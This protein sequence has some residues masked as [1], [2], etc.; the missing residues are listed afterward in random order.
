[1]R[2]C[3]CR[4]LLLLLLPPLLL[5]PLLLLLLPLPLL[6]LLL[7]LHTLI[8][9]HPNAQIRFTLLGLS[10]RIPQYLELFYRYVQGKVHKDFTTAVQQ[11]GFEAAAKKLVDK[12]DKERCTRAMSLRQALEDLSSTEGDARCRR[13]R[14]RAVEHVEGA[15]GA[16]DA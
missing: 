5:L 8:K 10:P 1:M 16:A 4:R 11:Y 6:L 2:A 12:M 3:E 15:G 14:K 9:T 7:L 13:K